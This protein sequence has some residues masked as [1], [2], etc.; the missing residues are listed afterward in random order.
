M[1]PVKTVTQP[2]HT[3]NEHHI[4]SHP[5]ILTPSQLHRTT[6]ETTPT[7]PVDEVMTM[8][9]VECEEISIPL[10]FLLEATP[11][12]S[13]HSEPPTP[14][15]SPVHPSPESDSH[16]NANVLN[17]AV[18]DIEKLVA[19]SKDDPPHLATKGES[20]KVHTTE[21]IP[22]MD[23]PLLNGLTHPPTPAF[24]LVGG[25]EYTKEDLDEV[26]LATSGEY[27]MGGASGEYGSLMKTSGEHG[28]KRAATEK[29]TA[30][31]GWVGRKSLSPPPAGKD[32]S[33][34]TPA[35]RGS[36]LSSLEGNDSL[37][38]SLHYPTPPEAPAGRQRV[39]AARA[40]V[41]GVSSL[42]PY[43]FGKKRVRTQSM[44][45]EEMKEEGEKGEG[46]KESV[47]IGRR[48]RKKEKQ[49]GEEGRGKMERLFV[50]VLSY[51]PEAMCTTGRPDLELPFD[52]G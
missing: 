49:R 13:T 32:G 2:S 25:R 38:P 18:E 3:D 8:R 37:S 4:H 39:L 17:T 5:T 20:E 50:A 44:E 43:M 51:D 23:N 29:D 34:P 47:R 41:P 14:P 19:Q 9:Q 24:T 33:L 40:A 11:S 46:R 35:G 1:P 7:G 36:H 28:G 6:G 48:E 15:A 21:E 52:E 10:T 31:A 12:D 22:Q 26:D 45:Q 42:S 30:S 16:T 27:S